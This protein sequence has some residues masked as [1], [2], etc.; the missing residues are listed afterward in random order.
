[1]ADKDSR[2]WN[3][4]DSTTDDS[5]SRNKKMHDTV[6]GGGNPIA[7][8]DGVFLPLSVQWC[9]IGTARNCRILLLLPQHGNADD[10]A[11]PQP[12]LQRYARL[13]NG[14][15]CLLQWVLLL[16]TR[17]EPTGPHPESDF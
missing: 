7:A 8:A 13:L 6:G 11:G 15:L 16:W 5:I 4:N 1:M 17:R 9:R 3:N 12:L 10:P 2:I 14:W